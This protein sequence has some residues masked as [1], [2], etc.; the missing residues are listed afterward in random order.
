MVY[1]EIDA[2]NLKIGDTIYIITRHL[3]LYSNKPFCCVKK[4]VVNNIIEN[5][6]GR[7]LAN[8][9]L[10]E[11]EYIESLFGVYYT[12]K[13]LAEEIVNKLYEKEYYTEEE[14]KN[15]VGYYN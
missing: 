12:K 4:I 6:Y 14:I 1:K 15:I 11:I 10:D 13:E 7:Y 8:I 3:G 5:K 2:T 9:E